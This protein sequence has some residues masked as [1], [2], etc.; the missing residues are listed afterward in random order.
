[1]AAAGGGATVDSLKA[2]GNDAFAKGKWDVAIDFYTR[3]LDGAPGNHVLYSNRAAAYLARRFPGDALN[4]ISDANTAIRLDPTYAKA[5]HRKGS[6]LIQIGEYE[7]AAQTCQV[8]ATVDFGD[9]CFCAT[10]FCALPLYTFPSAAFVPTRLT[11]HC[12]RRL[13][14]RTPA[15]LLSE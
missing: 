4:A 12:E 6:A 8:K 14:K 7:D 2:A 3:A 9:Q 15:L 5:Y 11:S 10:R 13:A 1:M